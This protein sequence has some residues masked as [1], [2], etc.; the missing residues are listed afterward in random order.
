MTPQKTFNSPVGYPV[1][2]RCTGCILLVMSFSAFMIASCIRD[3]VPSHLGVLAAFLSIRGLSVL[4]CPK[5]ARETFLY[6]IIRD[7]F[8]VW[9]NRAPKESKPVKIARPQVSADSQSIAS[10]T[11]I[12]V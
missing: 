12:A 8:A 1:W 10:G 5:P 3:G 9:K 6:S 4:T 11:K 2:A 7:T